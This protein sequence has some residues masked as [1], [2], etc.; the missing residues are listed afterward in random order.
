MKKQNLKQSKK[1]WLEKGDVGIIETI[2][3]VYYELEVWKV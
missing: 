2:G 3:D 1:M